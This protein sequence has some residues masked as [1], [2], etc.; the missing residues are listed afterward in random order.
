MSVVTP[1]KR[2]GQ[3]FLTDLTVIERI[4]AV[5][6]LN[7]NDR[8]VEIGPGLGALTLPVLK[9]IKELDAIE[10]DRELIPLLIDKT[11]TLGQVNIYQEDV[12]TVDFSQFKQDARDLHVFG[13]LPYNISTPLLFHLLTYASLITDMTVML[14][15]EVAERLTAAPN[16]KHYGR[17]SVM[18]Q[19]YCEPTLL[20]NIGAYAFHPPPKVASSIVRLTPYKTLPY[21]AKD[22][23]L[24]ATI[25]K[26]AF[27][28]RRKTLR[29]SLKE[30]ITETQW[31]ALSIN[32]QLRAEN[33]SVKDFVTISNALAHQ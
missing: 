31:V 30:M 5:L 9:K 17:L 18:L 1:R 14:Q 22:E 4:I 2:F 16:S 29:N 8:Y 26:Q 10:L 27:S 15:K 23:A 3:H 13:N 7:A 32:P 33:L 25:V 12:L 6:N 24:F 11:K 21:Q 20:F 28:Q 19:Y